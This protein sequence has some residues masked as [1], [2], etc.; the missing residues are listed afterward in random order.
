[1]FAPSQRDPLVHPPLKLH[2]V[3]EF[4]Q[5]QLEQLHGFLLAQVAQFE[6]EVREP[7]DYCLQSNGKRIRPILVFFSGWSRDK[8][9]Q[10][11]LVRIAAVIEIV[12]LATLVHD[13]I[14]D[15]ARIRHNCSTVSE[16]FG[17]QVAVLLGDALF[18]QALKLASEFPTVDVCRAVSASTRRVCSGEIAQS[19]HRGNAAVAI[20]DY[21]RIIRFKTAE[22]FR[23]SCYLGS[24]I[25]GYDE[26][27]TTAASVFGLHL[28]IAYQIF[29]DLADFVGREDNIG[30][31]LGTDLASGKF[32]L[33][34]ILLL[35]EVEYEK[36]AALIAQIADQ[37]RSDQRGITILM[38]EYGIF[39]RVGEYF[40]R[41]MESADVALS[42]FTEYIPVHHL[43]KI[44]SF[45]KSQI[46]KLDF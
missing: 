4:V 31:T 28:G 9:L 43:Q 14:L 6:P 16:K 25:G 27:F 11:E 7:V 10:A 13:D 46:E 2:D 41:E 20:D 5:P 42:S 38:D 34:L 22:L 37:S 24:R 39:E 29:D 23:L 8:A 36:R 35:Q 44:G 15:Q 12:H 32:T 1:M 30:K 33:P 26:E 21:L 45:V 17:P 19:L 40:W 3:T 18:S